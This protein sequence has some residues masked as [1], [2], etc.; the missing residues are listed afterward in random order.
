MPIKVVF[1]VIHSQ[2]KMCECATYFI[3]I[4][5][6]IK[7]KK[8]E[9]LGKENL[10]IDGYQFMD[11]E[12]YEK[13]K[14][15]QEAIVYI[16][17]HTNFNNINQV[18]KV[19]NK[20]IE[21]KMFSTII[22][23]EFLKQVRNLIIKKGNLEESEIAPVLITTERKD[24]NLTFEQKQKEK[25]KMLYENEKTNKTILKA[26]II[27]LVIVVGVMIYISRNGKNSIISDYENKIINQYEEWEIELEEREKE[28]E[29]QKKV[30]EEKE[31]SLEEK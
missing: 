21:K 24:T 12:S 8:A 29:E 19:Y 11:K 10:C 28:L 9:Y 26:A 17:A 6:T 20:A 16:K 4:I 15:E 5:L 30:I 3:Y 13:A 1:F 31:K 2:K 23:Y 14:K 18:I 27:V 25:Y 7:R 22:G